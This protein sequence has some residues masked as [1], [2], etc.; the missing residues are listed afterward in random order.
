MLL[1]L[2]RHAE[3]VDTTPDH[4]RALSARGRE[5]VARLAGFLRRSNA[6]RPAEL[7][8]SP[9][10]R[11]RETAEALG[12]ELALPSKEVAGITPDDDPQAIAGA[13]AKLAQPVALVGHEP[14]LSALASL[15]VTGAAQ[16]VVFAMKKGATLAL[17]RG[18]ARWVVR[19]HVEPGMLA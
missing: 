18:G 14:H 12:R 17:E 11:A 15:L 19:W 7:W 1:Y 4:A 8:H 6:F 13:L 16:P 9:L 5:Q 3:A 10:V 2:I